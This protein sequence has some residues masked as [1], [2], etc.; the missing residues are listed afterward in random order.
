[1][2][3]AQLCYDSD[4]VFRIKMDSIE[5]GYRVP[6]KFM[7]GDDYRKICLTNQNVNRP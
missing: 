4:S 5:E 7:Y 6:V 3:C 1:M 2:V